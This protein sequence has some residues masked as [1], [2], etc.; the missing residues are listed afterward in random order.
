[1][2]GDRVNSVYLGLYYGCWCSGSLCRQDITSHDIGYIEYVGPGLTSGR[3]LSTCIIPMW[4]NDIKCKYMF[5]YP[6]K[7]L[8]RK[9]LSNNYLWNNHS[10]PSCVGDSDVTWV[11]GISNHRQL[12]VCPTA[13][14]GQQ[15]WK[16]SPSALLDLCVCV[17]HRWAMDSSYKRPI[18]RTV[19][20]CYREITF[21]E[22]RGKISAFSLSATYLTQIYFKLFRVWLE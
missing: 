15:P 21:N 5:M 17:I 1:M 11:Y 14:S 16:H 3:I 20:W 10:L 19:E 22:E 12:T 2:C 7:N 6:L 9:G 4:S 8:A 18:M 13:C